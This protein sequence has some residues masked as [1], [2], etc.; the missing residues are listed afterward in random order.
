MENST[1]YSIRHSSHRW[2]DLPSRE[3]V[4]LIAIK[5]RAI[6]FGLF[7][8]I[9]FLHAEERFRAMDERLFQPS[10]EGVYGLAQYEFGHYT[11]AAQAYRA[12][13]RTG[14]WREWTNGDEAYTALLQGNLSEASRLADLRLTSQPDDLEAWL[15]QGE[16]A[17][18]K[19]NVK[20]ASGAFDHAVSLNGKHY[21]AL[22]LSAV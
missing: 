10:S 9:L 18:E 6:L 4:L 3:E 8:A 19:G 2:W 14:G 17:L 22:L 15:T 7:V 16:V 11:K 21:D 5:Y 1:E 20:Q 12:D 13:L